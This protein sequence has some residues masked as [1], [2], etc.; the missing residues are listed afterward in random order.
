MNYLYHT[1]HYVLYLCNNVQFAYIIVS[2]PL[3]R[4]LSKYLVILCDLPSY[5]LVMHTVSYNN[6][7]VSYLF[8]VIALVVQA[9]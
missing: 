4:L 3:G 9:S 1:L 5:H 8:S 2:V 6:I 7:L